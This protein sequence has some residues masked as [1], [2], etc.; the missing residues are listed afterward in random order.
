MTTKGRISLLVCFVLAETTVVSADVISYW[1]FN[2]LSEGTLTANVQVNS[3]VGE[4]KGCVFVRNDTGAWLD[5]ID[6]GGGDM[7]IRVKSASKSGFDCGIHYS[8]SDQFGVDEG[9]YT[10]SYRSN[11]YGS[12][13]NEVMLR[14]HLQ[15][16]GGVAMYGVRL[17]YIVDGS[18]KK[19]QLLVDGNTDGH[20]ETGTSLGISGDLSTTLFDGDWHTVKFGY[21]DGAALQVLVDGVPVITGSTYN[22]SNYADSESFIFANWGTSK[23]EG[24]EGDYD[25]VMFEDVIPEPATMGLLAAGGLLAVLRKRR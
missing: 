21:K 7:A 16:V 10:W 14:S 11:G 23:G 20:P 13:G 25:N 24:L 4:N 8:M 17:V 15:S 19:L 9:S 12:T 6:T 5:V 2:G 18:D 1:N 3:Q 22:S